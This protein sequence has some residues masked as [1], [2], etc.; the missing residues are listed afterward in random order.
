MRQSFG[1]GSAAIRAGL[2]CTGSLPVYLETANEGNIAIYQRLGF[3]LTSQWNV[4]GG[5]PRFWSM[6]RAAHDAEE[7]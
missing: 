6:M 7:R 2:A 1:H 3:G 4:P 5:G